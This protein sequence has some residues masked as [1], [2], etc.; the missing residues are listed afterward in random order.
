MSGAPLGFHLSLRLA[1]DRV[2]APSAEAR[3]EVAA[4]VLKVG[5][6]AE[7]LAFGLA[8]THLHLLAACDR[9]AAGRLAWRVELSV[10]ARLRPKVGF[11]PPRWWPVRDQRHLGRAFPYV[12]SQDHHGAFRDPF[13]DGTNLPDLLGLRLIGRYTASNVRRR[14]P[15][16]G[17]E[18]LVA[19]LE[20]PREGG[21]DG[22]REAGGAAFLGWPSEG[23]GEGSTE[24]GGAG[25]EVVADAAAAAAC[26]G[27]LAGRTA[28]VVAA[29]RAAVHAADDTVAASELAAALGVSARSLRRLAAE[30]PDPALVAAIRGQ[31]ALRLGRRPEGG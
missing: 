22:G 9:G 10:Q 1:D 5:R 29:R 13:R 14:L 11:D 3:R 4:A 12:L 6:E 25:A 17:R 31:I 7:L 8:D 23:S 28:P 16:V 15:R 21:D 24:S 30:S 20:G 19:L 26:L 2:I 27:S 18:E